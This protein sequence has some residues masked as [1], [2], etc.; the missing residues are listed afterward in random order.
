MYQATSLTL[1]IKAKKS[2]LFYKHLFKQMTDKQIN[3]LIEAL[4][5][6]GTLDARLLTTDAL[7]HYKT[8]EPN[9]NRIIKV[10]DEYEETV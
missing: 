1:K 8:V 6:S 10:F 2:V 9:Y 5:E 3:N 4:I 7:A